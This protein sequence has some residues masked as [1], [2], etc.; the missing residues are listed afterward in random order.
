MTKIYTSES[1]TSK[2]QV[3]HPKNDVINVL[4]NYSKSLEVLKSEKRKPE[5]TKSVEVVLN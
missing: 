5:I 2:D 3:K 1:N 4:L